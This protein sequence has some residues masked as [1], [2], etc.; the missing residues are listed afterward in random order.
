MDLFIYVCAGAFSVLFGVRNE[1]GM[2]V[3]VFVLGV[4]YGVYRALEMLRDGCGMLAMM[5]EDD[6][7]EMGIFHPPYEIEGDGE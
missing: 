2:V 4:Y 3:M 1:W 7:D 6:E 5:L